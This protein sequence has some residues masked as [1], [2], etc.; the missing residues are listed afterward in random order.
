MALDIRAPESVCKKPKTLAGG[1]TGGCPRGGA[2]RMGLPAAR[3]KSAHSQGQGGA[4][5]QTQRTLRAQRGRSRAPERPEPGGAVFLLAHAARL[6][7]PGRLLASRSVALRPP[8]PV[9]RAPPHVAQATE[10]CTV[11]APKTQRRES[12]GA[13]RKAGS[14]Q[15]PPPAAGGSGPGGRVSVRSRGICG[16]SRFRPQKEASAARG[17]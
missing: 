7:L 4:S 5:G 6:P 16:R 2:S 15:V 9:L 1:Q 3:N 11:S 12:Q 8:S 17:G 10:V 14:G 13:H